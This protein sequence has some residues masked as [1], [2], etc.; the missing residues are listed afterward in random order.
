MT[1]STTPSAKLAVC[2]NNTGYEASLERRKLYSVLADTEA[3]KHKLIRV[4]DES[5]E[6]YLYPESFFLSVALPPAARQ[7]VLAAA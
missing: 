7:A 3:K 6:D 5:G 4:I 1:A 2:V